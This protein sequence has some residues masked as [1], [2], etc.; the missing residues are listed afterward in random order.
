MREHYTF[1]NTHSVEWMLALMS[2]SLLY[3][4]IYLIDTIIMFE[5]RNHVKY[6]QKPY[7][8]DTQSKYYFHQV[9][10]LFHLFKLLGFLVLLSLIPYFFPLIRLSGLSISFLFR[11]SQRKGN[12]SLLW[13][14]PEYR[15]GDAYVSLRACV[16]LHIN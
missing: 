16:F 5:F 6:F 2:L 8:S 3:V 12:C 9:W 15:A 1:K 10:D 11:S 14:T 13:R 7:T 4:N